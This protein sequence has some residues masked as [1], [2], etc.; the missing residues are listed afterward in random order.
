MIYT[1]VYRESDWQDREGMHRRRKRKKASFL[2]EISLIRLLGA[3]LWFRLAFLGFLILAL[4]LA[5][6]LPKIWRT[7]PSG[8]RPVI[9]ISGLDWVQA[10]SLRR[11][12]QKERALGRQNQALFAWKAAVDHNPADV[13]TVQGL[14][15]ELLVAETGQQQLA[16]TVKY[17]S[18]LLQLTAT[19]QGSLE[20]VAKLADKL[21][22]YPWVIDLLHPV[23]TQLNPAQ[24]AC[25]L[26]ALFHTRQMARFAAQWDKADDRVKSGADMELYHAAYALGWGPPAGRVESQQLLQAAIVDP[27]LKELATRLLIVAAAQLGDTLLFERAFLSAVQDDKALLGD[28]VTYWRLLSQG[29]R[30]AEARQR[31]ESFTQEPV[32]AQE[33]ILL[34]DGYAA[35]GLTSRAKQVLQRHAPTFSEAEG[36]W[37]AQANLLIETQAWEELLTLALQIRQTVGAQE[38]LY[39]F[40]HFLE[41]RSF[42]ARDRREMAEQAFRKA[43]DCDFVNRTLGMA[44][45]GGLIKLGYPDLALRMLEAW[46]KE[47]TNNPDYWNL[48]CM[49]AFQRKQAD[50][51][52]TA[53]EAAY[54]LTP[55][56]MNAMNNYAAALL[57]AR[58]RPDEA[59]RLTVQLLQRAPNSVVAKI[60]HSLALVRNGRAAEADQLLQ[61]IS[62]ER[63]KE[64]ES[65]SYYLACFEIYTTLERWDQ[66]R[67]VDARINSRHLFPTQLDWWMDLRQKLPST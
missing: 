65:N 5:L 50:V 60:N 41:G 56:D 51:L 40:S 14:L 27:D 4:F 21:R 52:L 64:V 13:E 54:R 43:A 55:E 16:L 6:F 46:R 19:N 35:L 11:T 36:I 42:L 58:I 63:L 28:H 49:A 25:Y 8:V 31:A 30:R 10:W 33:V 29:G 38:S 61:S 37:I 67:Q 57:I 7:S 12:A 24:E 47:L 1:L 15:Q 32:S 3:S 23:A 53:A 2:G 9:K 39:G 22:L 34:A 44:T 17:G 48:L 45:A 62:L 66:A 59:I 20:L 26:R 18:W